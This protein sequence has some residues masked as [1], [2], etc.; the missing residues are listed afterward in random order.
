[1]GCKRG[2]VHDA[3][4]FVRNLYTEKIYEEKNS[5]SIYCHFICASDTT[6]T[7]K[8]FNDMKDF[9]IIEGLNEYKML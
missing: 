8:L 2:D 6:E 1:C 5:E 7:R 3:M 4:L 9:I